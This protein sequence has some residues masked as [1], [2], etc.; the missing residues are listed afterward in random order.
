MKAGIMMLGPAIK[1]LAQ[2][3]TLDTAG[4]HFEELG[5]VLG[6]TVAQ[7]TLPDDPQSAGDVFVSELLSGGALVCDAGTLATLLDNNRA[8]LTNLGALASRLRFLLIYGLERC[9]VHCVKRLLGNDSTV[10]MQR[11]SNGLRQRYRLPKAAAAISL[12]LSGT[13][14]ETAVGPQCPRLAGSLVDFATR[15]IE[16][17]SESFFSCILLSNCEVFL[18]NSSEVLNVSRPALADVLPHEA[19]PTL[20][21]WLFF[22]RRA[23]GERCWHN[24]EPKA[25]LVIDDPLL[26]PRYGFLSFDALLESMQRNSFTTTIAFIPW[27]YARSSTRTRELFK[28]N[29]SMLSLCVHG[30]D[31]TDGEFGSNNID[32]LRQKARTA[33]ER[34]NLHERTTGI[35]WDPVMVFPQGVFSTNSLAALQQEGYLA[36]VN[37][38]VLSTDQPKLVRV[39]DLLQMASTTYGGVPLFKRHYPVDIL[40]FALDLFLGKQVLIVE[41]HTYF[42]FGYDKAGEFAALLKGLEPRLEWTPLGRAVSG[43]VQRRMTDSG[44]ELRAY[45]DQ[46]FF[47]NIEPKPNH[48][49][50]IEQETDPGSV[51]GIT[52]NGLPVECRIEDDRVEVEF[53]AAADAECQI[54]VVRRRQSPPKDI[55]PGRGY[56]AKVAARRYLSEFRDKRKGPG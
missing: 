37:T 30:C 48:F 12:Q 19:Y 53:S 4:K 36:A 1:F 11:A 23:L 42:R 52:V 43:A 2:G 32:T 41:H 5:R 47:R 25:S 51:S 34:M 14:F 46:M 3:R 9:S 26:R 50:L 27:N 15:V 29:N 22:V 38:S 33:F 45:T 54:N 6:A 21:P 13:S 24:P 28:Q 16:S 17:N 55:A 10:E 44:T 20:L 18:L 35:A 49:R 39:G 7:V 56:S 31:H 40:P 8:G